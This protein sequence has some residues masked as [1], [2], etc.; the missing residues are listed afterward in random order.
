MK[1]FKPYLTIALVAVIM[2]AV[3]ERVP[4]LKKIVK[5]V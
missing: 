1:Q 2:M 5:G 3:V 4:Q